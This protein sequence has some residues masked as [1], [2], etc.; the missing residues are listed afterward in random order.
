MTI[1]R[2]HPNYTWFSSTD[3]DTLLLRTTKEE[4]SFGAVKL[5]ER[6]NEMRTYLIFLGVLRVY[7]RD[8]WDTSIAHSIYLFPK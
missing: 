8:F 1:P 5:H 6:G 3:S 2:G 7:A 4:C